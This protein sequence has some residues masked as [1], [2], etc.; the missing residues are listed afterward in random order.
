MRAGG[1][2]F[3]FFPC[4]LTPSQERSQKWEGE[5]GLSLSDAGDWTAYEHDKTLDSRQAESMISDSDA[6]I[7]SPSIA[8]L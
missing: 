1:E 5:E 3:F 6:L 7:V 8:V 2:H 4:P